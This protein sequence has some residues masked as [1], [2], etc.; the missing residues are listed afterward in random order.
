MDADMG[1]AEVVE[2]SGWRCDPEAP[3]QLEAAA[4]DHPF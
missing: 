3:R 4:S 2:I 1:W